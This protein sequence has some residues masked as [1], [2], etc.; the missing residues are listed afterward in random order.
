[1]RLATLTKHLGLCAS[2]GAC[3]AA[4]LFAQSSGQGERPKSPLPRLT[5]PILFDGV[6]NDPAWDAVETLPLIQFQPTWGGPVEHATELRIAYDNDYLYFSAR[7]FDTQPI[8]AT[9]YRRDDWSTRD[10]QVAIG[11]D[12]FNDYETAMAFALYSTGA[13]IDAQFSDDAREQSGVNV[14]WNTHWDGKATRSETGWEAE[15]RIPWSS[16]RFKT[17]EE[18]EEVTMGINAFRYRADGGFFYQY[19]GVRNDWGFWSFLKPSKGARRTLEGI[20]SSK[21]LYITPFLT[22]G[23]GQDYALNDAG[24]A[25]RRDDN[26]TF[27]AGLDLKY[28]LTSDLTLDATLNTDFA[29]VEAD[30]QQVNLTRFSL[31]FP[32]KRQFFLEG[33][34]NFDF[35]FGENDRVF[36]SRR[37]GLSDGQQVRLL[38]GGRVVGRIGKWDVG[39]LD[40]QTGRDGGI[41]SENFGV[42]RL[43]RRMLNNNSYL[44]GIAT[45]RVD[46]DGDSN[47]AFGLDGVLSLT[48]DNLVR[49]GWA[50]TFENDREN[51]LASADNAR[52]R[53][54]LERPR[55]T[56]FLYSLG[57]GGAGR[58]YR[59]AMGFQ[60]RQNYYQI[61][62]GIGFGWRSETASAVENWSVEA[63]LDGWYER[64]NDLFGTVSGKAGG[65]VGLRSQYELSAAVTFDRENLV[66]GFSLSEDADIPAGE[67][68]FA[69]LEAG[70]KSPAGNPFKA[71]VDV[72][73][74]RFYDGNRFIVKL[75]PSW[76]VTERVAV[77]GTYQYNRLRFDGRGQSFDAHILQSRTDLMVSTKLTFSVFL[78]YNSSAN[79]IIANGRFRF[80][81]REGNDFYLVYNEN[82][83]TDRLISSPELPFSSGRTIL[84]KYT[85]T[86]I[87]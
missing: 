19:P 63:N 82:V 61:S 35:S 44:G 79:A 51:S 70:M 57:A 53:I 29:Q 6:V 15:I 38:G 7:C 74:G 69:G 50:Q 33:T 86:F 9:T 1:L 47:T 28:S 62:S 2:L 68:T 78:Q 43:K 80:N 77:T 14:N 73:L 45:S 3:A 40:L 54:D 11:I 42:L 24:D 75:T 13:R 85:Y 5:E 20:S 21:P 30:A 66:E 37:V 4:P 84:A 46:Q 27:D 64:E 58:E 39:L 76:S 49:F 71:E 8:T 22:S 60:R 12:S 25:Y 34:S 81:P 36:H 16:L 72:T 23:L 18:G 83:N 32:E 10:D 67:F 31:F 55:S 65:I 48:G 17:P 26:V 41:P 56:G 52:F 59:P 87:R